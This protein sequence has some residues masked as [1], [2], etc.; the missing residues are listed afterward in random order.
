MERLALVGLLLQ[1]GFQAVV[2]VE[3]KI[4][5]HLALAVQVV[6]GAGIIQLRV[7]LE[8]IMPAAAV[9]VVVAPC[10]LMSIKT[11]VRAAPVS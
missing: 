6:E 2:V 8:P 4:L 1:V 7:H 9:V 11:A 10:L 5:V 3:R